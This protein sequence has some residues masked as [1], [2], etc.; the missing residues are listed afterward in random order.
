MN[1]PASPAVVA[2]RLMEEVAGYHAVYAR[3]NEHRVEVR[4]ERVADIE[5][6]LGERLH[7]N[8]RVPDLTRRGYEFQGARLLGFDGR[9]MA[10][11]FYARPDQPDRPLG[12]CIGLGEPGDDEVRT[13]VKSGITVATW[14]RDEYI[15]VLAGWDEEAMLADLARD[16]GRDL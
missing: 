12:V 9:P 2:D 7:R 8:V 11:L 1:W 16:L 10:E 14:R 3:E 4:A 5:A 15:Y 6:W 13:D